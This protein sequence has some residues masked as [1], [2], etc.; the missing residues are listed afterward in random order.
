MSDETVT[1]GSGDVFADLGL[2]RE[3]GDLVEFRDNSGVV[4]RGA[5]LDIR[6]GYYVPEQNYW[7]QTDAS[8]CLPKSY[9]FVAV[10]AYGLILAPLDRL[11]IVEK[12]WWHKESPRKRRSK[13]AGYSHGDAERLNWLDA[14][15]GEDGTLIVKDGDGWRVGTAHLGSGFNGFAEGSGRTLREAFDGAIKHSLDVAM[16][17]EAAP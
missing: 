15:T 17:R 10:I 13:T 4:W 5:L 9:G 7:C 12:G 1:V 2:K 8:D 11:A 14:N 16:D 3:I 6:K